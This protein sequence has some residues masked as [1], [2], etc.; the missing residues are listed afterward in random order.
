MASNIDPV[1]FVAFNEPAAGSAPGLPHPSEPNPPEQD[2]MFTS[3]RVG[4]L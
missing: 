1:D 4:L 2:T 3:G